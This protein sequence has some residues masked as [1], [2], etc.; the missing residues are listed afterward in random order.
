VA[1]PKTGYAVLID[2]QKLVLGG[3]AASTPLWAGLIAL[4]NQGLGRNLGFINP[5]LYSK[6]GPSGAL[7]AVTKGDNGIHGVEGYSAGPGW[8]AVTG[9]GTPDGRKLLEAFRT[10]ASP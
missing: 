7:R 6:I 8:N 3:T 2:G 4:L 5:V 1:S 9:W 10:V